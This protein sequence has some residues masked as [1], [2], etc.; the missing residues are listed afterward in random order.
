VNGAQATEARDRRGRK[1][2]FNVRRWQPTEDE[3]LDRRLSDEERGKVS[4]GREGDGE[5]AEFERGRGS[6]KRRCNGRLRVEMV[7]F[8]R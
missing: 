4:V 7:G 1:D 6:A 8:D 2:E 3:L 5:M